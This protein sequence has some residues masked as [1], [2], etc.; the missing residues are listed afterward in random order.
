MI[1]FNLR[2]IGASAYSCAYAM[3]SVIYILLKNLST[4]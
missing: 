3:P 4:I 1:V 2:L